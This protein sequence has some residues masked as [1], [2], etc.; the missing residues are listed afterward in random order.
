MEQN[1]YG[2]CI[3]LCHAVNDIGIRVDSLPNFDRN[4]DRMVSLGIF[5]LFIYHRIV[6][7]TQTKHY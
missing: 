2:D 3:K 7:E 5:Y 6:H 1:Y 4:I